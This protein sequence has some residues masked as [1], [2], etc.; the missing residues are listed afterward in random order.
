MPQ[1]KIKVKTKVPDAVKAKLQKKKKSGVAFTRRANAPIQAKKTKMQGTQKIKQL[2]S[3]AVNKSVEEDIRARAS[4]GV[5][6]FSKAQ[7]AVAKHNKNSKAN[8]P[9]A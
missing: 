5:I 6:N 4:E 9:D 2:L 7:H 8:V 3:K 1:G